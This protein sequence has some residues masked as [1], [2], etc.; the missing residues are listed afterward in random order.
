MMETEDVRGKAERLVN[1][2]DALLEGIPPA[3]AIAVLTALIAQ[4]LAHLSP[5]VRDSALAGIAR[6]MRKIAEDVGDGE[7]RRI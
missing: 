7:R 6:M 1:Q 2:M 5:R 4:Y 3:I